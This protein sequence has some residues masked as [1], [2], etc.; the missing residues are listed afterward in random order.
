MF[1]KIL[2]TKQHTRNALSERVHIHLVFSAAKQEQN[3]AEKIL[4]RERE[5]YHRLSQYPAA[6]FSG[7]EF[8]WRG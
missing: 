7:C 6:V 3:K 5:L 8:R 4:D 2:K 1:T